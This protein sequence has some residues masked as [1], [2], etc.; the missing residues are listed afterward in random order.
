MQ[1]DNTT[2]ECKPKDLQAGTIYNFRIVSLDGEER[3]VVLQTGKGCQ[4][5][6]DGQATWGA[7]PCLIKLVFHLSSKHTN[8]GENTCKDK[9][10]QIW[11]EVAWLTFR[12]FLS[13]E[14][15]RLAPGRGSAAKTQCRL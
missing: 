3:V 5:L 14:N 15:S 11:P 9:Y 8:E 1:I 13:A 10:P 12:D 7:E 2:Y 6:L 4:V